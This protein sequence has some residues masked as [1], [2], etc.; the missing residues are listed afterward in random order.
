MPFSIWHYICRIAVPV[1]F[2]ASPLVFLARP[3]SVLQRIGIGA[4]LVLITLGLV[5]G[6]MGLLMCI[7]R[8]RMG[9]PFC[10]QKGRVGGGS[11]G[12]TLAC[13]ACGLVYET[14][15]LKLRLARCVDS[16]SEPNESREIEETPVEFR[17]ELSVFPRGWVFFRRWGTLRW[18]LLMLVLPA[19]GLVGAWLRGQMVGGVIIFGMGALVGAVAF[20]F[21]NSGTSSSNWGTFTRAREPMRFWVDVVILVA[22]YVAISLVGWIIK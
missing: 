9:C 7:D 6:M 21:L 18:Y 8:L 2:L 13:P 11:G 3:D 4:I 22:I 5:G 17:S 12:L 14:G 20:V 16:S 10:G 19:S 15:F 1:L